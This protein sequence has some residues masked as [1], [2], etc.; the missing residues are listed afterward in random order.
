MKI[1]WAL[2]AIL[3]AASPQVA[4]AQAFGISIGRNIS[5]YKARRETVPMRYSITPPTPHPSFNE[6]SAYTD[7]SGEICFVGAINL[8]HDKDFAITLR[9]F[10]NV[11]TALVFKYGNPVVSKLPNYLRGLSAIEMLRNRTA[12]HKSE[13]TVNN[14]NALGDGLYA[15]VLQILAVQRGNA[16][17][18][19]VYYGEST[20]ACVARRLEAANQGL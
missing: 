19:I 4:S 15:I 8:N 7:P 16:I 20:P 1:I 11:E 3:T 6:Y 12:S 10:D 18:S 14:G 17:V 9:K 13:W 2:A 5:E